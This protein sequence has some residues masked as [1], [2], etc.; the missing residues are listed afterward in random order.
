MCCL[1]D[2]MA[3]AFVG[4]PTFLSLRWII[5]KEL[6]CAPAVDETGAASH[7]RWLLG[8]EYWIRLMRTRKGGPQGAHLDRTAYRN[9]AR[10]H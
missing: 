5:G 1:M 8:F 2:R 4:L 6:F 7:P 3:P 10:R 9:D